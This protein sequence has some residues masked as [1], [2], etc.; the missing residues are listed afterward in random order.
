MTKHKTTW[1]SWSGN[2]FHPIITFF[3]LSKVTKEGWNKPGRRA[4]FRPPG[5][6]VFLEGFRYHDDDDVVH[7][8]C[9]LIVLWSQS[10]VWKRL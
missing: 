4:R 6:G 2:V 3:C 1:F 8:C 5:G 9:A 10:V 7:I